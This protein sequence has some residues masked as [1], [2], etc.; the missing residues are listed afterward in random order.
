MTCAYA[1]GQMLSAWMCDNK[2][3]HPSAIDLLPQRLVD[4]PR[5]ASI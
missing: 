5:L 3:T 2:C 1:V 4:I